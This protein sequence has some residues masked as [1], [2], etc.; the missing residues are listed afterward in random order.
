MIGMGLIW[1]IGSPVTQVLTISPYSHLIGSR[2]Q[3]LIM[4]WL[5]TS[6]DAGRNLLPLEAS[7]SLQVAYGVNIGTVGLAII[8]DVLFARIQQATLLFSPQIALRKDRRQ[9]KRNTDLF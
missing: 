5:T 8:L 3:G 9:Q 2:P 6:G 1:S 4:G 7:A